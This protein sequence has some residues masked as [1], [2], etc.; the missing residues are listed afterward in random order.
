M[1]QTA[2]TTTATCNEKL[3][4]Q[5]ECSNANDSLIDFVLHRAHSNK[6]IK[7]QPIH[8]FIHIA[9]F[10]F[11][12]C[13]CCCVCS[14]SSAKIDIEPRPCACASTSECSLLHTQDDGSFFL[15]SRE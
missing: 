10:I 11:D 4:R 14:R 8:Q 1:K 3:K 13:C 12:F 9:Y 7:A 5:Y 2:G 6:H 15:H